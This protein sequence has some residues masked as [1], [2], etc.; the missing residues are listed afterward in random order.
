M[1][2]AVLLSNLCNL[3]GLHP[4]VAQYWIPLWWST[5]FCPHDGW[6]RCSVTCDYLLLRFI[7]CNYLH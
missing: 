7:A 1:T 3:S 6:F 5:P 4:T 2:G